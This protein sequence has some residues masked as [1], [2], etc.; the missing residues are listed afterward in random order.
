MLMFRQTAQIIINMNNPTITP[1]KTKIKK[2][3]VVKPIQKPLPEEWTPKV[4]KFPP[5][6]G[7]IVLL[8]SKIIF[9]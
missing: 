6:K 8:K 3:P 2:D 1:E 5:P 7:L 4:K 9:D